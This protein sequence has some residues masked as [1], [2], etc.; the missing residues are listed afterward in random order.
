MDLDHIS[1]NQIDDRSSQVRLVGWL[2]DPTLCGNDHVAH[3]SYQVPAG[4]L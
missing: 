2:M 1:H 3:G 4:G